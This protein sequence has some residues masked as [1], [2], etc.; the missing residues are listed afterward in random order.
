MKDRVQH[1]EATAQ[2]S[3]ELLSDDIQG[4]FAA[5]EKESE[6]DKRLAELKARR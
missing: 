2:A 1:T 4:K 5:M 6:I 3:S